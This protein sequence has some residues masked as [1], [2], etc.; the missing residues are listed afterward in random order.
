M[1]PRHEKRP[2]GGFPPKGLVPDHPIHLSPPTLAGDEKKEGSGNSPRS[3]SPVD[4]HWAPKSAR[5]ASLAASSPT[6]RRPART[7]RLL[8]RLRDG[9]GRDVAIRGISGETSSPGSPASAD[10][11]SP[12]LGGPTPLRTVPSFLF[13]L[14]RHRGFLAHDRWPRVTGLVSYP[15]R[16]FFLFLSRTTPFPVGLP[17]FRTLSP[18]PWSSPFA[19]A[20]SIFGRTHSAMVG[21]LFL[22]PVAIPGQFPRPFASSSDRRISAFSTTLAHSSNGPVSFRPTVFAPLSFVQ[23]FGLSARDSASRLVAWRAI[24]FDFRIRSP[25]R[26]PPDFLFVFRGKARPSPPE[27]GDI[28]LGLAAVSQ[29]ECTTQFPRGRE[30]QFVPTVCRTCVRSL[31]QARSKPCSS[32]PRSFLS[33]INAPCEASV[34]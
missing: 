2:S 9:A 34:M 26:S 1:P 4:W 8:F 22:H 17:M 13:P 7:I 10:A 29:N 32:F 24:P 15:S 20:P 19:P 31:S 28:G 3:L 18:A 16:C 33:K 14:G 30:R 6:S 23:P 27:A 12:N 5:R 25:H 11:R 21:S